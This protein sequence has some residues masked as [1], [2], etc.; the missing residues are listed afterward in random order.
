M[1]LFYLNTTAPHSFARLSSFPPSTLKKRR[2]KLFLGCRSNSIRQKLSCT[3]VAASYESSGGRG[4]GGSDVSEECGECVEV[5]VVGSRKDALLEFCSASPLLSPLLRFWYFWLLIYSNSFAARVIYV[6]L[7]SFWVYVLIIWNATS[8]L[9][10]CFDREAEN[11]VYALRKSYCYFVCERSNSL[12]AQLCEKSLLYPLMNCL[13]RD[14]P[15][16]PSSIE[17]ELI[18]PVRLSSFSG[19]NS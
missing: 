14:Y 11:K 12:S 15:N 4:N 8:L 1:N 9:F 5:I 13:A 16:S 6:D 2:S 3:C 19:Y 10:H 7:H 17:V 18:E